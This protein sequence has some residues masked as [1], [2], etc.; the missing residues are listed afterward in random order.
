MIKLLTL[1][2][3]VVTASLISGLLPLPIYAASSN[4]NGLAVSPAINT[5]KAVSGQTSAN[6]DTT[7]TNITNNKI[8]VALSTKDFGS[9]NEYGNVGFYGASYNS[10]NNPHSLSSSVVLPSDEYLIDAHHSQTIQ[11]NI[12]DIDKLAPGGH[13]SALIF[14]PFVAKDGQSKNE[15]SVQPSVASLIFLTVLGGY[16]SISLL[17]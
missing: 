7:V 14:T 15:V 8:A 1:I 17:V 4:A 12:Q 5:I 6:F 9:L 16:Q 3:S 13:Y 11:V 2:T 10:A